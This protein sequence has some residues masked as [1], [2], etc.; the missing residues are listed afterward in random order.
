L[1]LGTFALYFPV[2]RFTFFNLD[3]GFYVVDNVHVHYGLNWTTIKWA[4]TA[5]DRQSWIPLSFL[6]HA[7]DYQLFGPNPAGH[8]IVNA[9]LHA[10]NALLLFWVLKRATGYTGRSFMVAA[11]FAVHPLN[12]EA[13]AW[14]AERKTVLSMVFFLLALGAYRWY[15]EKPGNDR[16]RVVFLLFALGL[17]AKAQVI[18]LPFVL[19][20]WDY[21]P[22]QR[23]FSPKG[24]A[25][26]F[27]PESFSS[28]IREKV[29]L[30]LLCAVDAWY[31]I[32][33]EGLARPRY[34][35]PLSHSLANAVFSYECY[36]RNVFWP[37]RLAPL[38]P[39]RGSSLAAWQVAGASAL[40]L[41]ITGLV[42]AGR[43]CR[44]LLV[45]WLWF[46]GTL[47]PMLQV[48]QFGREGV[49]DRFVYQAMIGLFIMVCWGV[50]DWAEEH[51]I[52]PAWLGA[53]AAVTLLALTLVA[54]R[55]IGYW[56][57]PSKMWHHAIAVVKDD[58]I[59][60]NQ[61]AM[62]D[63]AQGKMDE[64]LQRWRRVV[65]LYPDDNYSNSRLALYEQKQGHPQEAIRYYEH[66]VRDPALPRE[67]LGD[68][69]GNI[70]IAYRQMGDVVH[71]REYADKAAEAR[72]HERALELQYE[73]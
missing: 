2:H 31:T 68:I 62:E 30:L 58:W 65:T 57:T 6:S 21:W 61:L 47:V 67:Y 52:A 38:I 23:M 54:H 71:A 44:Y 46:L 66:A 51:K 70:S 64:A 60:D 50:S 28:L 20:L 1:L 9:I 5:F 73:R 48:V 12:V 69:Y 49:S 4:F 10:L 34:W 59:A 7:L 45:G 33:S 17:T 36:I 3:D 40:L 19:L 56:E 13:V 32:Y 14:V 11:L 18:T 42:I 63:E 25:S 15:A 26:P 53:A 22:L 41:A 39:N 27:S 43:R 8:H 29:S 16:Y 37:S 35:P 55:Q 72:A 24:G